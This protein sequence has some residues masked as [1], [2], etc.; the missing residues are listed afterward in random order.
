MSDIVQRMRSMAANDSSD[1]QWCDEAAHEIEKLRAEIE[2][3]QQAYTNLN[4]YV[5]VIDR[6][7]RRRKSK[8]VIR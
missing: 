8:G 3:L 5:N 1:I 2:R 7:V 6:Q 4:A